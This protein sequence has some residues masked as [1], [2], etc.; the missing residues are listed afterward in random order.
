MRKSILIILIILILII[1]SIFPCINA[2][3]K[4][5]DNEISFLSYNSFKHCLIIGTYD[6]KSFPSNY[7]VR[8]ESDEKS[9]ILIGN[10][11]IGIGSHFPPAQ[12]FF[13]KVSKI[14]IE[15]YI[16][17]SIAGIVIGINANGRF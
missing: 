13:Y 11:L 14:N 9:I 17:F 10:I 5:D 16:G 1:Q 12:Y 6:E 7:K 2:N 3:E 4:I 8:L 15:D